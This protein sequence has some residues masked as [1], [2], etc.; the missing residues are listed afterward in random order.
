MGGCSMSEEYL[1]DVGTPWPRMRISLDGWAMDVSHSL[2]WDET[3]GGLT[4]W[5][6]VV[7]TAVTHPALTTV[8]PG[9]DGHLVPDLDGGH[10]LTHSHLA[11]AIQPRQVST[12]L[13]TQKGW[14][15]HPL[16]CL[17]SRDRVSLVP[18]AQ[19]HHSSRGRSS[20]LPDRMERF[21]GRWSTAWFSSRLG[22]QPHSRSDPQRPVA[23]ISTW[24]SPNPG[25][26]M[27]LVS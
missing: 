25:A 3:V 4:L 8:D 5:T 26:S 21:S 16:R 17:H 14:L 2:G 10:A 15:D 22:A 9:L 1:V 13:P 20:E 19:R 27:W 11:P 24:A 7:T 12:P 6:Q 23:W 18:S